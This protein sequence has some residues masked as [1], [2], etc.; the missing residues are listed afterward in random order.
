MRKLFYLNYPKSVLAFFVL[1]SIIGSFLAVNRLHFSFNME[2]FFPQDDP[3]LLYFQEFKERFEPDDNFLLLAIRREEGVFDSSFLKQVARASDSIQA[4]RFGLKRFSARDSAYYGQQAQKTERG[5]W[6]LQPIISLQSILNLEYPLKTPFAFTT[7]PAL[8]LDEPERYARDK[9]KILSDE[10]LLNNLISK[11]AKTLV[12]LLKTVDNIEQEPA[13]KLIINLHKILEEQGLEEYHILGRANFQ[14]E[15]VEMQ[16][17]E[18]VYSSLVSFILVI[19][20]MWLIFR[21]FWSVFIAGS[22]IAM[23]LTVFVGFLGLVGGKLDSMALLY[24]IVMI[25]VAT[26]DMVHVMSKYTDELKRGRNRGEAMRITIREMGAA[27]FLTSATTAV[28]FASL[29]S[30][31]I[32][33]IKMF[34]VYAALGVLLAYATVMLFTTSFLS[35]FDRDQLIIENKKERGFDFSDF[36]TRL[37]AWLHGFTKRQ[38]KAIYAGAVGLFAL[39]AWGISMVHTNTQIEQILPKGSKLTADF[40]F[41]EREFS[42]FRPFELALS[43]QGDYTSDDFVVLQQINKLEEQV[44]TY[45]VIQSVS[46]ITALYKSLHRA[47][48]GDQL[49]YYRMPETEKDFRRYQKIASKIDGMG[50]AFSFLVSEDKKYARISARVLDIGGDHIRKIQDSISA[51]IVANIDPSI[52]EVQQTGTGIIVDKNAEYMR[53]SLLKGLGLSILI[54]SLVVALLY[55]RLR[56]LFAF[57]IPN[58]FPLLI[59][60]A[61]LGFLDIPLEAGVSIVFGI[62]FGISVDDTIHILGRFRLLRGRGMEVEEAL[63]LTLTETGKALCLTSL[64]LFCGFFILLFS[65]NPPAVTIGLLISITLFSALICD[66]LIMPPLLRALA[67]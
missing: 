2:D 25:I 56:I 3:D 27:V 49:A 22:S 13:E 7:I 35:L 47:Y 15:M 19:A 36:W 57:L 48:N 18:F 30:S 67:K 32:E 45:D 38:S 23:G 12:L 11:D 33:P 44:K 58:I 28:G 43:I 63:R 55:K 64:I 54:I 26:S 60:G 52:V 31:R 46:S 40:Q 50:S 53:D 20:I 5:E 41:F 14:K 59:A 39:C 51:W 16:F 62:I 66:L 21:R 29:L 17:W 10:R 6:L 8:H 34:G 42:G 4:M 65:A 61:L 1:F 37:M 9:E 24:P